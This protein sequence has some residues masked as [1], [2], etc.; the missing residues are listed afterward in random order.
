MRDEEFKEA[1]EHLSDVIKHHGFDDYDEPVKDLVRRLDEH[2]KKNPPQDARMAERDSNSADLWAYGL[3]SYDTAELDFDCENEWSESPHYKCS[4]Y[5][6]FQ[7]PFMVFEW[8][9]DVN[10]L[11]KIVAEWETALTENT[12]LV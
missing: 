5:D 2:F 11:Q 7:A 10:I 9:G 4:Y 12:A 1:V 6:G 8:E 3:L